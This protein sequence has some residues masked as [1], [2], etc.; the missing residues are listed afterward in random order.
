[1]NKLG[2]GYPVFETSYAPMS[3]IVCADRQF[4]ETARAVALGGAAVLI[5]NSYGM[6]GQGEN[7]RFIR[8][9]AYEN[10]MYVLFCHPRETVL[11]SPEGRIIASTC[12]WEKILVR[13]IDPAQAERRGLF[14][15]R[16]MA[17]TYGIIGDSSAYANLRD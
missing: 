16:E 2:K 10:G 4:P 13:E 11:C 9:R 5:I 12:G 8:Q 15:N 14:G 1:M 17:K 3:V 7:E 6:W